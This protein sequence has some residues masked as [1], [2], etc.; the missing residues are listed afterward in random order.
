[1]KSWFLAMHNL[2]GL[3]LESALRRFG[4]LGVD[5]YS[6]TKV[7][8]RKRP[9]C[10]SVRMVEK[11]LFPGYLFLRFDP[12][13]VHTTTISDF[14]GMKGFV[15]FGTKIAQPSE[16]LI[17][18]LKQSIL[19]RLD[20]GVTCIEFRNLPLEVQEALTAISNMASSIKR[21]VALLQLLQSL[22]SAGNGYLAHSI[23]ERS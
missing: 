4:L 23:F 8:L 11:P 3:H 7:E 12:E 16:L 2:K 22:S 14:H 10:T 6:P 18:A 15:R 19:L 1:M 20:K 17:Q 9:D 5:S 21:E 13:Q